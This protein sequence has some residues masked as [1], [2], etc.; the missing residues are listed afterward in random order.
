VG[1]LGSGFVDFFYFLFVAIILFK[2]HKIESEKYAAKVTPGC[3]SGAGEWRFGW[4]GCDCVRLL[5]Q[6][7]GWM[8]FAAAFAAA[9][10]IPGPLRLGALS[11]LVRLIPLAKWLK[12]ALLGDQPAGYCRKYFWVGSWRGGML[13]LVGSTPVATIWVFCGNIFCRSARQ[14][15]DSLLGPRCSR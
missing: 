4:L 6:N 15:G 9:N 7:V 14:P 5:S 2:S 3:W 12:K 13:D 10:A 1:S 8:G 11:R